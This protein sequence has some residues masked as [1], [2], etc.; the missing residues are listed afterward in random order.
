MT[1]RI[2]V[3]AMMMFSWTGVL[4]FAWRLDEVPLKA[5]LETF[6]SRLGEWLGRELPAFDPRVVAVLGADDYIS[7]IYSNPAQHVVGLYIGYHASQRQGD[8]IHSPLNCLP[9]AGWQA[10]SA[11]RMS[12][13]IGGRSPIEVNRYVVEKGGERQLVLYWYQS[14][15]RVIASEYWG[16]FYLVLDSIR[17]N[18][19]DA[20]LVRIVT[21][22]SDREEAENAAAERAVAFL[23]V[24]F[25]S[26]VEH[27]PS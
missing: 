27:L 7:R 24:T 18:R 5:R 23:R 25:P 26:L 12:V 21:P 8:S 22:I 4:T 10:V 2:A 17:S 15:G 9:G 11:G 6:P 1:T 20:A 16:K 13:A 3:L 14:H 19:S